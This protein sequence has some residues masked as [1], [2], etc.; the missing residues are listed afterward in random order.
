VYVRLKRGVHHTIV[1]FVKQSAAG[2]HR[3]SLKMCSTVDSLRC[4]VV[5]ITTWRPD[6][7]LLPARRPPN[8]TDGETRT[9]VNEHG[10][11][12]RDMREVPPTAHHQLV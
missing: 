10:A 3:M 2:I 11:P 5:R 4:S 7:I 9:S 8:D 6:V 12:R 1:S